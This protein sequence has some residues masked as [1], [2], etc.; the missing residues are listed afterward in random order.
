M[1]GRT[2][3]CNHARWPITILKQAF[4]SFRVGW[5]AHTYGL[6]S[7]EGA[8]RT[9]GCLRSANGETNIANGMSHRG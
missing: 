5:C 8:D 1:R 9:F 3:M 2:V 4:L 6:I 7:S